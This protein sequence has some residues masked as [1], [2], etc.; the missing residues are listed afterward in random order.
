VNSRR[1]REY[2]VVNRNNAARWERK[3]TK[4]E[5][6]SFPTHFVPLSLSFSLSFLDLQRDNTLSVVIPGKGLCNCKIV[7]HTSWT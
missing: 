4:T 5:E 2:A 1:G 6:K 7:C 3:N